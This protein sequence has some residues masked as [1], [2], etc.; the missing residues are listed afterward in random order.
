[1]YSYQIGDEPERDGGGQS[2]RVDGRD[3]ILSLRP[4]GYCS[5]KLIESAGQ[6]AVIDL[7]PMKSFPTDAGTLKVY[8]RKADTR[9][10]ELL[11]SLLSFLE[12]RLD[13]KL[14]LDHIDRACFRSVIRQR[15]PAAAPPPPIADGGAG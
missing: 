12:P 7:R 11:S 10:P 4:K 6:P 2:I 9:W 15:R 13:R 3:G 5:I 1:G 8:R 14:T